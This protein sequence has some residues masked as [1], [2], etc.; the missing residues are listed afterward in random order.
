M[1]LCRRSYFDPIPGSMRMSLSAARTSRVF[2]LSAILFLSSG[3]AF[4]SHRTLGTTPNIEPP[5]SR[6]LDVTTALTHMLPIVDQ[7]PNCGPPA[8]YCVISAYDIYSS[9]VALD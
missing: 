3:G 5:S 9:Q 6:N 2:T 1:S 8:E 7:S 4:F